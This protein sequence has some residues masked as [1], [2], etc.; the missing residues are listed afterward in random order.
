MD[1]IDSRINFPETDQ[2]PVDRIIHVAGSVR[3]AIGSARERIF[4]NP[5]ADNGVHYEDPRF[6]IA[7]VSPRAPSYHHLSYNPVTA[8]QSSLAAVQMC[9]PDDANVAT[10]IDENAGPL[11]LEQIAENDLVGISA[12]TAM[13]P[14]AYQIADRLR[15]SRR[16]IQIVM[17]GIH[18]TFLPDE[19][20]E[21]CDAIVQGEAECVWPELL[22]DA[23]TGNLKE[24]Y[25]GRANRP[26]TW[27]IPLAPRSRV[28][29]LHISRGCPQP[30]E[31][32]CTPNMIGRKQR[33]LPV[34]QVV[35]AIKRNPPLWP[36]I[37]PFYDDNLL[38]NR[39]EAARLAEALR[40]LGIRWASMSSIDTADDEELLRLLQESGYR[41][42]LIGFESTNKENLRGVGKKVNTTRDYREAVERLHRHG[43]S[44]I[45]SFI[46][47]MDNDSP[48]SI[49]DMVDT[50]T[51]I[52]LD[53]ATFSILTP[54]PGTPLFERL[55]E[56]GRIISRDWNRYTA[57]Q[58]VF[59]PQQMTPP[60]LQDIYEK[61]RRQFFSPRNILRRASSVKNKPLALAVNAAAYWSFREKGPVVSRRPQVGVS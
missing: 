58:V 42:S 17:G 12:A 19:A 57:G 26:E 55:D 38:T 1:S 3:Q 11:N 43:I 23:Q 36:H 47:G 2:R 56:E 37:V 49:R 48:E 40:P 20:L 30:C 60:E 27:E 28:M 15:Q 10:I 13:A 7:L 14:R 45:G 54:F 25:D 44:V 24:R 9:T 59:Q 53:M 6:K 4:G 51:D 61:T 21:H 50:L 22:E 16:D 46:L 31:F 52:K 8:S 5:E 34:E 18:P 33:R 41:T 32:C 39:E 29:P 35:E